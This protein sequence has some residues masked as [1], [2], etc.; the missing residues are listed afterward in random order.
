MANKR[1]FSRSNEQHRKPVSDPRFQLIALLQE[2]ILVVQEGVVVFANDPMV[3]ALQGSDPTGIAIGAL[4]ADPRTAPLAPWCTRSANSPLR[5]TLQLPVAGHDEQKEWSLE[6]IPLDFDGSPALQLVLT[7]SASEHRLDQERNRS[8]MAEEVNTVLRQEIQEHRR[9]QDELRRSRQFARS[10]VNSSLD[11]IIA[12]GRDGEITEF[13]PAAMVRFGYEPEEVLGKKA[14]MLYADDGEHQRIQVELNAHGA[15]AGEVRNMDRTGAVFTSFLTASRQYDEDG[16]LLGSMGVSRDITRSKK[17]ELALRASEE[18]YRDLFEH[19]T[20]LIQSVDPDGRFQYVNKAWRETM[21]YTEEELAARTIWDIV[22]PQEQAQCRQLFN[23]VLTGGAVDQLRTVFIAKDGRKVVVEGNTNARIVE[24]RPTALRSIFR[25]VTGI[26]AARADLHKQEAKLRALFESSDHMFWT[27]DKRVALTGFNRGYADMVER[28][29]GTRPEV[30][31]DMDR[32]RKLFA[33]QDYHA[34]WEAK[35][36]EAFS[37]RAI[38]FETDL[39]DRNGRR[40]CNEIFLSPVFDAQG[41]VNEVFGVGHEVTEQ[42]EAEE[43]VREQAAR[44][45]A[46]FESSANMMIWTLD[47]DFRITALN[48]HFRQSAL[49]GMDLELGLGD[50]FIASMMERVADAR[51]KPFVARYRAALAGEPQQFEV[52]LRNRSGR[53]LWVEN[54]LNPIRVDGEVVEVSCLAYGITDK[55]EAQ[56]KLLESLHEKEVLLKEVHHRVKNNLQIISSILNLQGGYVDND[57][58]MLEL[59]RESQGRIRSMSFIHESLYQNKNFSSIDLADYIHGLSRNLMHSHN[60]FGRVELVEQLEHVQLGLD[61]AI[62]CGLILN[63]LISNAFK[64]AFPDGGKG[65][66][67]LGLSRQDRTV[68]I[69][70]SDNGRGLPPGFEEERD[71]N[72][73]L[74]LVHTLIGQLDGHI[75]RTK[76]P[77]VGYLITFEQPK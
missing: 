70:V 44:L 31:L 19:A 67:E 53:T 5:G 43:T 61:Q 71:A 12:V 58:R 46:I 6:L 23:V 13:N 29:Y 9:T 40:V 35:Y 68:L 22:E 27:V 15:F 2:A 4:G 21:G 3:R 51:Y 39:K 48:E 26:L 69:S 17:D 1:P 8:R 66:I 36:A 75:T 64:H 52:E 63:E 54:F 62:P 77:G 76:A 33:T 30:N 55:K 50:D 74:Q 32:P 47:R 16:R 41:M 10:L 25:D 56:K 18:R 34:F 57:P 7:G 65:V 38:R 14:R 45:A 73:G 11:M 59:L 60:L 37:G 28:L 72:L 20:D 49:R 42:K 24:G